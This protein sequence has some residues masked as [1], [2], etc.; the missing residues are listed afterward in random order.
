MAHDLGP[1]WYKPAIAPVGFDHEEHLIPQRKSTVQYPLLLKYRARVMPLIFDQVNEH[2]R[3]ILFDK[4]IRCNIFPEFSARLVLELEPIREQQWP[5][6]H[7]N[8]HFS[9]SLASAYFIY[10]MLFMRR[11][12]M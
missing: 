2:R 10:K 8:I 1:P 5:N 6:E 4:T 12:I 9:T 11:V 7:L 3:E